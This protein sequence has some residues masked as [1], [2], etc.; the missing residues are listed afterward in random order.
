LQFKNKKM[1]LIN[2]TCP[3]RHKELKKNIMIGLVAS[4]STSTPLYA[5]SYVAVLALCFFEMGPAYSFM[6]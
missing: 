4:A 6:L 5:S 3:V 2:F 1:L